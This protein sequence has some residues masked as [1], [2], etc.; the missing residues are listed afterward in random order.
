M[1][2]R[3]HAAA[4][5]ARERGRRLAVEYDN[6]R[7]ALEWAA[8]EDAAQ[9]LVMTA[10]LVW[11]WSIRGSLREA[12]R[13]ILSA[14]QVTDAPTGLRAELYQALAAYS[15]QAGDLAAAAAQR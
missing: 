1:V 3:L 6:V 11:F 9:Q 5:D 12:R 7:I 10:N 8:R 4:D 15:R 13:R 2:E 14:V